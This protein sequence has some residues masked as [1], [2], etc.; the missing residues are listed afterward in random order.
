MPLVLRTV[1]RHFSS[2]T[3]RRVNCEESSQAHSHVPHRL[4]SAGCRPPYLCPFSFLTLH[5]TFFS[6][7]EVRSIHTSLSLATHAIAFSHANNTKRIHPSA[8]DST[9]EPWQCFRTI[10]LHDFL[11]NA[12]QSDHCP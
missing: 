4:L 12:S 3:Q 6:L 8:L 9:S 11:R 5:A 7:P 2:R 10:V 1:A